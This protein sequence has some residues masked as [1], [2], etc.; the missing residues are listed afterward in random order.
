MSDGAPSRADRPALQAAR[1]AL[2]RRADALPPGPLRD[3]LLQRLA[4]LGAR[5]PAANTP[6]A[7]PALAVDAAPPASV[8]ALRAL[9]AGLPV[10][11]AAAPRLLQAQPREWATL[12]LERRLAAPLKPEAAGAAMGPLNTQALVPRALQRLQALSPDYLQ[13]LITQLDLMDLLA[14]LSASAPPAPPPSAS[15]SAAGAGARTRAS[16][17]PSTGP[18]RRP[19]RT[20]AKRA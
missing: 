12:R 17:K 19:R 9:L 13:R 15:A 6:D 8:Q 16:T 5:W 14:P 1:A 3:A 4:A 7:V 18:A 11:D 20:A 10:R 2:Q